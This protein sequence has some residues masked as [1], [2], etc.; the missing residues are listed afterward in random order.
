MIQ[1]SNEEHLEDDLNSIEYA[2]KARNKYLEMH[3][4]KLE[5]L[6]YNLSADVVSKKDEHCIGKNEFLDTCYA[7]D[8]YVCPQN[9]GLIPLAM[10]NML[11]HELLEKHKH[12]IKIPVVV[13]YVCRHDTE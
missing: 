13:H 12:K 1:V 3:K 10:M 2:N 4:K 7:M 5:K 8:V 11:K 9:H 6:G